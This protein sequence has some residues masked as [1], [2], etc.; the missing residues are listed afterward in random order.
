M[1]RGPT[2]PRPAASPSARCS[3]R[4]YV[5]A[6]A[7]VTTPYDHLSLLKTLALIFGV[8]A[9]ARAA[10]ADVKAFGAKVFTNA[11]AAGSD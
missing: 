9:P 10:S 7:T 11:P 4:P 6:G 3:S 5:A 8:P 2:R 1:A